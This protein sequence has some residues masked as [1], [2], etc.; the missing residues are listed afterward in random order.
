MGAA[1]GGGV[2]VSHARRFRGL[3]HPR[4]RQAEWDAGHHQ[5][6]SMGGKYHS[7]YIVLADPFLLSWGTTVGISKNYSSCQHYKGNHFSIL[8]RVL[9]SRWWTFGWALLILT[10][11][12]AVIALVIWNQSLSK[13]NQTTNRLLWEI[14]KYRNYKIFRRGHP[15]YYHLSHTQPWTVRWEAYLVCFSL[16]S[17]IAE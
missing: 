11:V 12:E 15:D 4:T 2:L 10:E 16:E 5:T 3:P 9:A 8:L 17:I 14:W 6:F 1:S 13:S 7:L